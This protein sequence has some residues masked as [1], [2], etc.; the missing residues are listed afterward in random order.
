MDGWREGGREGGR[1]S[2]RSIGLHC[3]IKCRNAQNAVPFVP[4]LNACS[5][6][7]VSGWR[8]SSRATPGAD[9]RASSL[10]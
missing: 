1:V 4:A 2:A 9:M 5:R 6:L 3:E 10:H 8:C 7:L